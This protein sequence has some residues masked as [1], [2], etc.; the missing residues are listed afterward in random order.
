MLR[1]LKFKHSL[2]WTVI[3]RGFRN[4]RHLALYVGVSVK[5]NF[6]EPR[7]TNLVENVSVSQ[8]SCEQIEP[9]VIILGI[10]LRIGGDISHADSK[11]GST[12]AFENRLQG[13]WVLCQVP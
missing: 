11:G 6:R 7:G 5:D 10:L 3:S 12:T 9:S 1:T 4:E 13:T 2:P 8:T